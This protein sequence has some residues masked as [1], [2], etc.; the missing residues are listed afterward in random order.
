VKIL[1]PTKYKFVCVLNFLGRHFL[2][3]KWNRLPFH[4]LNRHIQHYE[5]VSPHFSW[6]RR[7]S[8][9]LRCSRDKERRYNKTN[10]SPDLFR[11]KVYISSLSLKSTKDHNVRGELDTLQTR[12][13]TGP[14]SVR[15]LFLKPDIGTR[16][17]IQISVKNTKWWLRLLLNLNTWL[18]KYFKI[19]R[20]YD[21]STRKWS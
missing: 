16:C 12:K 14:S 18:E 7:V 4:L 9:D 11:R 13:N 8:F 21:Y 19:S 6:L 17:Y 5:K 1:S 20:R 10:I 3:M 15:K 2:T